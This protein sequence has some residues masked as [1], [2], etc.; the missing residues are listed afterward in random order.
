MIKLGILGAET[1]FQYGLIEMEYPVYGSLHVMVDGSKRVQYTQ[2]H[3]RS[4]KITIEY[5]TE[6]VWEQVL[7]LV[8]DSMSNDLNLVDHEGKNFTVRILPESIPKRPI[9]GTALGYDINF[10][11]VEV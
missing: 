4:F 11:V 5:V 6:T 8:D 3:S 9:R 10:G 7:S 1:E 2:Q